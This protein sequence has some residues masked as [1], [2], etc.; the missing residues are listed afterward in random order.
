MLYE[1]KKAV[2]ALHRPG[3]D[4]GPL[5]MVRNAAPY[6]LPGDLKSPRR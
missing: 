2:Q 5:R 3:I 6:Y 1:I 4:A